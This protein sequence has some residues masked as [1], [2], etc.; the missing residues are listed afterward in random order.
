MEIKKHKKTPAKFTQKVA[1]KG[2]F[3]DVLKAISAAAHKKNKEKVAVLQ[4]G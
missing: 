2:S 4:K 1:I 3:D